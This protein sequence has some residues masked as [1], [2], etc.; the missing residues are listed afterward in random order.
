MP[1]SLI[2][3]YSLDDKGFFAI[4]ITLSLILSIGPK[5]K[6]FASL[7]KRIAPIVKTKH[8]N[9]VRPIDKPEFNMDTERI[10]KKP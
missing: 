1:F 7:E 4:I 5:A 9:I 6:S 10:S 2:S 3:S 8:T